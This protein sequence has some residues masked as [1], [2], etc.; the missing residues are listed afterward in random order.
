M[1]F[2]VMPEAE[3]VIIFIFPHPLPFKKGRE[4]HVI[5]TPKSIGIQLDCS[6]IATNQVNRSLNNVKRQT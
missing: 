2:T 3:F 4:V 6:G 1:T 5:K